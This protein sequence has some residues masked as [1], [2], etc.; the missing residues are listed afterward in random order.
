MPPV[1]APGR[2]QTNVGLSVFADPE[3]SF[4]DMDEQLLVSNLSKRDVLWRYAKQE[5]MLKAGGK[6]RA[7]KLAVC[8]KYLGDPR[9][10]MGVTNVYTIPGSQRPGV[11]PE[12]YAEL[13]RLSILYGIYEGS[14]NKMSTFKFKD[15]PRDRQDKDRDLWPEYNANDFIVPRMRVMTIEGEQ[16]VH[17][18]IFEPEYDPY[19]YETD[20][21][22]MQ[23]VRS[24]FDSLQRKYNAL[25]ERLDGLQGLM[26]GD[27]EPGEVPGAEI[28]SVRPPGE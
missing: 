15:T 11:V 27:V 25:A 19:R 22:G 14:L 18:P 9:S 1:Q 3:V 2:I 21:Q 5:W 7:I 16:E 10:A 8:V 13:K 6:P 4:N 28:D 26:L 23:D 12:R 24:E 17:F 20:V